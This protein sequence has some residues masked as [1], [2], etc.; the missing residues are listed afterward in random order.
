MRHD[1]SLHHMNLKDHSW[2]FCQEF[3]KLWALLLPEIYQD[4]LPQIPPALSLVPLLS[5]THHLS[6]LCEFS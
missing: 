1:P 3:R 5:H 4:Q 6:F 2:Y